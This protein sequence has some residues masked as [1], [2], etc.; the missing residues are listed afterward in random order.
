VNSLLRACSRRTQVARSVTVDPE[1]GVDATETSM[2]G[3]VVGIEGAGGATVRRGDRSIRAAG[4]LRSF[5]RPFRSRSS[6]FRRPPAPSMPTDRSAHRRL[7]SRPHRPPDLG[8]RPLQPALR[9]LHARR[10]S[11]WVP[12]S[13]ILTFEEI[14]RIASVAHDLGVDS[15]R[16]TGGEPLVRASFTRDPRRPARSPSASRL[17][18]DH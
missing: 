2:S 18:M 6:S 16:L 3:P 9:L 15:L 13:E 7:R 4:R 8:D 11:H 5:G 17:S 10:G 12:R 14:E 1:V